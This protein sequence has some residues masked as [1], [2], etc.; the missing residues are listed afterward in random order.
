MRKK[1]LGALATAWLFW[2]STVNAEVLVVYPADPKEFSAYRD[3]IDGALEGIKSVIGDAKLLPMINPSEEAARSLLEAV[4]HVDGAIWLGPQGLSRE[5]ARKIPPELKIVF[6]WMY[7]SPDEYPNLSG[8]TLQTEPDPLFEFTRAVL[9]KYERLVYV[10]HPTEKS[11]LETLKQAAAHWNFKVIFHPAGDDSVKTHK[12]L[13]PTLDWQKE[14][15]LLSPS[16]RVMDKFFYQILLVRA[17]ELKIPILSNYIIYSLAGCMIGTYPDAIAYGRQLARMLKE[18]MES[19]SSFK[20]RIELAK[21][22]KFAFNERYAQRLGV[23]LPS[24]WRGKVSKLVEA[25]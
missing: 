12:E 5:D 18:K 10:F 6:G 20:P 15:F 14:A 7:L 24:E 4:K 19:G 17:W 2:T 1:L 9:P 11:Y 16:P 23:S 22:T 13:L 25:Y 3:F 8:V 21:E